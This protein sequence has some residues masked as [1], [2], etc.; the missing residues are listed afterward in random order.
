MYIKKGIIMRKIAIVTK[1]SAYNYGA[2]LQAYAL[3]STIEKLGGAPIIVDFGKQKRPGVKMQKSFSGLVK[4]IYSIR[5]KKELTEGY[6]RFEQFRDKSLYL[7][8][9]Y[10]SYAELK[11]NPPEADVYVVG[12][13]QVWNPLRISETNFLRFVPDDKV[14]AS[15]AASMGISNIP[16]GSKR[17]FAEYVSD[18]D[19]ISVREED[20]KNLIE[21]STEQECRVDVDPVFL[22][23]EDEWREVSV[24]SQIKK[25]YILCYCIYRPQ[26]LNNWLKKLHNATGK[27]IVVVTTNA[28]R[29]LYHNRIVRNAGPKEM[30]GLLINADFVVSSSFHGV[31]LSIVNNKPFYAII[32]PDAPSRI[33]NMLTR[34][35]LEN[36]ILSPN[37]LPVL[38]E[39][40]YSK[41]KIAIEQYVKDSYNYI[42]FLIKSA[43]KKSNNGASY[44]NSIK[45]KNVEEITSKCTGCTVCEYVCPTNAIS[46]ISDAYGFKYPKV[47]GEKC[48]NCGK[49]VRTCHTLER[50]GNSKENCEAYYGWCKNDRVR[51]LSSSGGF[52][53]VIAE[54]VLE[55]KGLIFGAYFD[56]KTKKVM[57]VSSD[58]VDWKLFRR[59]KYVESDME[60]VFPAIKQAIDE[61]RLVLF[62]GTPCQCAGIRKAFGKNDSLILCDF[63]CHGVPSEK[64]FKEFLL[65]K[66][67]CL[68]DTIT[69]YEF[70]TNGWKMRIV[71]YRNYAR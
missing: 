18:F 5:Y 26:W 33:E 55:R 59:S 66:E 63:L 39:I 23:S 6:K 60:N 43:E 15:Y 57:H 9:A 13:D 67:K 71:F 28:Y 51:N 32:N 22:L 45:Y 56:A 3:Q 21:A 16:E 50:S 10:K 64:F 11:N 14:K 12:S 17:L 48:V 25:P 24:S 31:A 54:Y 68:N 40:D 30:L 4:K 69:N 36:R 47:D 7:S 49:C 52:F 27:D 8:N 19:F 53:S 20:A 46:F 44:N 34:F 61:G 37:H 62:C 70:R 38:D 58:D 41:A 65:H 29:N 2:M 1:H 35:H 42:E